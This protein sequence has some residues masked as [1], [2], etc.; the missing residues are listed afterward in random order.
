MPLFLQQSSLDW[1]LLPLYL[2]QTNA[3]YFRQPWC[4]NPA[5]DITAEISGE[6]T[7]REVSRNAGGSRKTRNMTRYGLAPEYVTTEKRMTENVSKK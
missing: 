6:H 5:A 3:E 1:A 2:F 7:R 4:G